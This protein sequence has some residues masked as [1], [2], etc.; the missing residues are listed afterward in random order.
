MLGHIQ[1]AKSAFRL[2]ASQSEASTQ[3]FEAAVIAKPHK[4]W[5]ERPLLVIVP[6]PGMKPS[7]DSI[8]GFLKVCAPQQTTV[9]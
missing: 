2:Q 9:Y 1:E 8:L 6:A 7:K 5:L 3:V 4:K